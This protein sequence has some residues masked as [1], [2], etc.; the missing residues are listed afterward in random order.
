MM[1]ALAFALSVAAL[2]VLAIPSGPDSLEARA[3]ADNIVDVTDTNKFWS[4]LILFPI[5]T[6]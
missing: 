2:A 5:I 1:H 4:E 6:P 3:A